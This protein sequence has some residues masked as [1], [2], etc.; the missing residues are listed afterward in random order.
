MKSLYDVPNLLLQKFPTEDFTAT[1]KVKFMPRENKGKTMVG[2]RA[3]LVVM[4]L[5]YAVLALDSRADGIYL[6]Q[7][8]CKKADP[9][10]DQEKENAAEQA[11]RPMNFIC[12]S[13]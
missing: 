12:V 10:C 4:G 2:E 1:T 7:A 9:R 6:V 11:R 3:G 5:D 13:K 8:D